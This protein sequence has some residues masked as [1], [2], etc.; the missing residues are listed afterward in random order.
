MT[1]KDHSRLLQVR[2]SDLSDEEDPNDYLQDPDLWTDRLPQP[3]RMLDNLL[4]RVLYR[5]W[6]EI[7]HRE[8]ERIREAARIKIPEVFEWSRVSAVDEC[9]LGSGLHVLACGEDG[10]VFVGGS[11]GFT[12]LKA[13]G[14]D[15]DFRKI[16]QSGNLEADLI[17]LNI[18]TNKRVHF[19]AVVCHI[20]EYV[21]SLI[22]GCVT[23][24]GQYNI[25]VKIFALIED[26]LISICSISPPVSENG[27]LCFVFS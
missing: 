23:L 18:A 2:S 15:N 6:D 22:V 17:N 16:A 25:E 10:Y 14:E 9:A 7:E 5:A 8:T 20:G 1:S 19:I 3:F 4:Q 13:P 11:H 12:V 24:Y 21:T 26:N 27:W